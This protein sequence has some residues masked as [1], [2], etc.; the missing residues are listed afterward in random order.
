MTKFD[1]FFLV[2][3]SV[4]AIAFYINEWKKIDQELEK[5]RAINEKILQES[6]PE[7]GPQIDWSREIAKSFTTKND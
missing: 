5:M 6:W 1:M 2:V 3:F 7:Q 4:I